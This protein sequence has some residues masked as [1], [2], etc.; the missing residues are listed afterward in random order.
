MGI[1]QEVHG[2]G[3][4]QRQLHHVQDRLVLVQ[5]HVVVG[6]GHR[7]ERD[8]LGV[9]EERVRPPHVLEPLDLQQPVLGGHVL[10][11]PQPVVLP[12]L[13]EE[14]VRRVRHGRLVDRVQSHDRDV[15]QHRRRLAFLFWRA[16]FVV[17]LGIFRKD[18]IEGETGSAMNGGGVRG[19]F[20][21]FIVNFSF[22]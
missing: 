21:F 8:R 12:G 16:H 7:L 11:Q 6:D 14:D 3:Q 2:A 18:V 15:E 9:L 1:D 19:R 4:P 17:Q 20:L 22:F 13:R 10:R 5:P